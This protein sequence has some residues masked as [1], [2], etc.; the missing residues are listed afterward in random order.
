MKKIDKKDWRYMITAFVMT[1]LVLA[2]AAG[3]S[4]AV[5]RSAEVLYGEGESFSLK[6]R[7][8]V[9]TLTLFSE[10]QSFSFL[11]IETFLLNIGT[12]SSFLPPQ[13][14]SVFLS[15]SLFHLGAEELLKTG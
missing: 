3:V 15:A 9:V 4:A 12:F 6:E 10:E 1:L 7:N 8:G 11:D 14:R 2:F 13:I 5:F